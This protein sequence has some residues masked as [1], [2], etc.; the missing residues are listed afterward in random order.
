MP[1]TPRHLTQG[2]ALQVHVLNPNL[3]K[4]GRQQSITGHDGKGKTWRE[5]H[6]RMMPW[7]NNNRP[8]RRLCGLH[9]LL[10]IKMAEVL[11]WLDKGSLAV[12]AA[13][14]ESPKFDKTLM[15]A[16]LNA[17]LERTFE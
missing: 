9:A 4:T 10:A 16:F 8:S 14:W 6:K 2:S 17:Q 11:G 1:C 15:D 13:V 5:I 7:R 12:P 3:L